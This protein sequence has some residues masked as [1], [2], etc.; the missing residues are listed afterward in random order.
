MGF[1]DWYR[2]GNPSWSRLVQVLGNSVIP[3]MIAAL[4]RQAKAALEAA[5]FR[6]LVPRLVMRPVV[7]LA[8]PC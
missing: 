8:L 2:L 4:A 6:R 3:P 5:D 1:P 7:Q